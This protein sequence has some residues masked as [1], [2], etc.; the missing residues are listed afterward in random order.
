VTAP[1]FAWIDPDGWQSRVFAR[2]REA[3]AAA[4]RCH[5]VRLEA[6]GCDLAALAWPDLE[7]AGWR[8]VELQ[9][10]LP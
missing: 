3:E 10:G 7:R 9:A 8:I 5:R 1:G 6:R 4:V 2:R